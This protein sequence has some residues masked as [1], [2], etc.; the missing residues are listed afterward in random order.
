MST[1]T[2]PDYGFCFRLD[3]FVDRRLYAVWGFGLSV[4]KYAIEAIVV[5]A[6]TGRFYS[7]S[8]FLSPLL[9][10]RATFTDGAPEWLGM[11]LVLWTIPFVWVAV[12][13]SVRRC[14]DANLTPWCA[15]LV[16]IP[17]LNYLTMLLLSVIPS[18]QP[19]TAEELK[20]ELQQAE[21]WKAPT[22]DSLPVTTPADNAESSGLIAALAGGAA[23]AGYAMLCTVMTIY[24]FDSYGAALFFGTPIVA[25]AVSGFLFNRPV[26]RGLGATE[27]HSMLMM[28]A[29]CFGFLLVGLEGAIC[30]VMA[31]PIMLPL[32]MMGAVVGRSIAIETLR[33]KRDTKGMMWCLVGLPLLASIE[34]VIVPNPTYAV[35]TT[36]DIQAAPAVVWQKVIAFPEITEPP[37]WFFRTGIASPLRA[38]IDGTG[39]GAMRYCEFTTGTF[40]E[41]IT[42]WQENQRLAFDVTEQPHPMFEMTPYRHIHP[43][44]LNGAFRSTR[45]EFRLE[46]LPDGGTRLTGTTWYVLEMH[47]QSYWTLWT[48]ELIHQIHLRVLKHIQSVA[49]A[50]STSQSTLSVTHRHD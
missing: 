8:D 43:P 19:L 6:L 10:T 2:R 44:H 18:I 25:G 46:P 5:G 24:A 40:V 48:D 7:P 32:A 27:L 47:P 42:V 21:L 4:L 34:G 14:R 12:A 11:G 38:H 41:P 29:C 35:K 23:G 16:L 36:I 45:G 1:P 49:E 37:A 3:G 15:L 28:I 30:I 13:M 22:T 33:V 50:E 20:R 39:V 17:V 9:S 26:R 31:I